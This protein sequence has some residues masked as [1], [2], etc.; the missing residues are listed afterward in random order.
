MKATIINSNNNNNRLAICHH[1][2]LWDTWSH[3]RLA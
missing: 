1:R 3:S 2:P